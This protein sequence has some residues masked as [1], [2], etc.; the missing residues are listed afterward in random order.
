MNTDPPTPA[1]RW[2]LARSAVHQAAR[3]ALA[4]PLPR[5]AFTAVCIA[6]AIVAVVRAQSARHAAQTARGTYAQAR[7][8]A[9]E[10]LALR[11]RS[12][13]MQT[14][15]ASTADAHERLIRVLTD[16]GLAT[17]VLR[18]LSHE[19]AAEARSRA[20]ASAPNSD[21]P[22][23][24][25]PP[26]DSL[27]VTLSPLALPQLHDVLE[28]W[29]RANPAWAVTRIDIAPAPASGPASQSPP[30]SPHAGLSVRL[31]IGVP[32]NAVAHAQRADAIVLRQE[33]SR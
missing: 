8:D 11:A 33:P 31:T 14:A 28:G 7:R 13:P 4:H 19:G 5:R 6:S 21:S 18:E 15:A 1:K 32:A 17:S 24:A 27:R 16:A 20:P 23:L 22:S 10:V 9:E 2:A 30:S 3:R 12:A 25:P 29:R 26:T